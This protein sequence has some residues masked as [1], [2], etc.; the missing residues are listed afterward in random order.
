MLYMRDIGYARDTAICHD[1]FV[2]SQKVSLN[3]IANESTFKLIDEVLALGVNLKEV[4][5]QCSKHTSVGPPQGTHP[6]ASAS[7]SM[8]TRWVTRQGGMTGC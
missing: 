4:S 8:W 6:H 2:C 3:V 1:S 5:L 7:R